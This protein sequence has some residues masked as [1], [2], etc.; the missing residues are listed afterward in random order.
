MS[1]VVNI[2]KVR[3][4]REIESLTP[5]QQLKLHTVTAAFNDQEKI[6]DMLELAYGTLPLGEAIDILFSFVA[7]MLYGGADSEK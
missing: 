7:Q 5:E 6:T 2:N 4:N 1:N 3:A